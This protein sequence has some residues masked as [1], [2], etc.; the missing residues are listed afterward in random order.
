[1]PTVLP[2][3]VLSD[4]RLE[5]ARR[6]YTTATVDASPQLNN[7]TSLGLRRGLQRTTGPGG[8]GSNAL[9]TLY[10]STNPYSLQVFHRSAHIKEI[11]SLLPSL[12]AACV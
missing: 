4:K 12:L 3:A 5:T 9:T 7:S 8:S 10:A 2:S 11:Q 6:D 1:M